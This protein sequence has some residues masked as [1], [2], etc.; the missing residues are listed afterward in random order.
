VRLVVVLCAVFAVGCEFAVDRVGGGPTQA[1]DD[2]GA[3]DLGDSDLTGSDG[4]ASMPDLAQADATGTGLLTVAYAAA[5]P[6]A[7]LTALG[8]VDWAHWGF[9]SAIDFDH[10][11]GVGILP[12]RKLINTATPVQYGDN[13]TGF[14]WTDGTPHMT[15]TNS[16]TGIFTFGLGT[17]FELDVPADTAS[18]TLRLF[19]GGYRA[20]GTLDVSL[21]DGSAPGRTDKQSSMTGPF[22]AFYTIQFRAASSS[23]KLIVKWTESLDYSGGN[24]TLQA[25]AL[26]AP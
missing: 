3:G 4:P 20:E 23:Q 17:G 24:V 9:T 13:F 14:S 11:V 10:K 12:N 6:M 21:S 26:T 19:V 15:A 1:S 5:P 25:A 7:D 16:T 2:L 18:H 8:T 22:G